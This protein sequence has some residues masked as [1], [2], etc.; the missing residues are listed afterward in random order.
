[1]IVFD[2]YTF[3]CMIK[4][5]AFFFLIVLLLSSLVFSIFQKLG[6]QR[7]VYQQPYSYFP[8]NSLL[9][10]EIEE[11][12]KTVNNFFETNMIWLNFEEISK[13]NHKNKM[14][15]DVKSIISD[16]SFNEIFDQGSTNIAFYKNSKSISWIIAKNIYANDLEKN[17]N[18]DSS[19]LND[20]Y[21]KIIN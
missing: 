20:C 15:E 9:F 5:F 7:K 1:M 8:S 10:M 4:R 12:S 6:D 13:K 17:L 3:D 14:I 21:F 18:V 19:F 16:S 2:C 11:F